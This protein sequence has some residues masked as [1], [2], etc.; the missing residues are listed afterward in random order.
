[1][2]LFALPPSFFIYPVTVSLASDI[3]AALARGDRAAAG[4][5]PPPP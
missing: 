5:A 3:A 4:A 1:M 2:T